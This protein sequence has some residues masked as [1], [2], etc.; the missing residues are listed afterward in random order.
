MLIAGGLAFHT[1]FPSFDS[2]RPSSS[3]RY[4]L[5]VP[6]LGFKQER[7]LD[8][9]SLYRL[10]SGSFV[11]PAIRLPRPS[12]VHSLIFCIHQGC[13]RLSLH[14]PPIFSSQR[15]SFSPPSEP[16]RSPESRRLRKEI[17]KQEP[18]THCR[19]QIYPV[20]LRSPSS[21]GPRIAHSPRLR[22]GVAD[23]S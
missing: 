1:S 22:I 14:P 12:F 21:R 18:S 17:S 11:H 16:F 4:P 3:V 23:V 9:F 13:S 8:M 5:R 19:R 2:V 6:R 10:P 20:S 15:V 7:S